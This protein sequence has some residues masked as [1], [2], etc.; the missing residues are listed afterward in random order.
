MPNYLMPNVA[1]G[2]GKTRFAK[3]QSVSSV[4]MGASA[5]PQTET[6]IPNYGDVT[7]IEVVLTQSTA[8]TLTGAKT[9]DY[10]LQSLAI[11][12]K[13]GNPIWSSIR[14]IDLPV[15]DRL[16]N[17]GVNRTV[18]TT[19]AS[20]ATHRWLIPCNIEQKDQ[21]SR[22]QV[23]LA[24]Y[25]D[26]ATSGATGGSVSFDVIVY[27]QD[28]TQLTFSQRIFRLT[29]SLVSGACRFGPNL[30]KGTT[31]QHLLF[32]VGTES[33]ISQIDFSADGSSE[34]NALR[35]TDLQAIEDSRLVSG[36]VTGQFSLFNSPFVST[37]KT[38]L[39]VQG[40]GS[41]TIEWFVVTAE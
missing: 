20:S 36:H 24:P 6:D 26:M 34:L 21:T 35:L 38:R 33:N 31:I 23:T 32:K 14:G 30:P 28:Q 25:S 22:I 11:K 8:G 13:K 37:D 1:M 9:L 12:D 2:V 41:D 17:I 16:F 10:S 4:S 39:D 27:Y 15:L 19:S 29:Q 7:A 40:A 18:T 3:V 5:V